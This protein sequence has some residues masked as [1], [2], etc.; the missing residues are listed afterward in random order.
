MGRPRSLA[1][2]D[3][4][5][6]GG[7]R[8]GRTDGR[9]GFGAMDWSG[10]FGAMG[11]GFEATGCG[12]EAMGWSGVREPRSRSGF[13]LSRVKQLCGSRA[14]EGVSRTA[15]ASVPGLTR[16]KVHRPIVGPVRVL[17]RLRKITDRQVRQT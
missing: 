15:D 1:S 9:D 12:F 17:T 5:Q 13:C 14:G 2:V 3:S 7:A 6:M 10:G 16:R 11:C 4:K 8:I